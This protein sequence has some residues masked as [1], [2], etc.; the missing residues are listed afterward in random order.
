MGGYA[1]EDRDER[2]RLLGPWA[3]VLGIMLVRLGWRSQTYYARADKRPGGPEECA[4]DK[5]SGRHDYRH[6]DKPYGHDD[7]GGRVVLEPCDFSDKVTKARKC[8]EYGPL[9][10]RYC[11]DV[12]DVDA[13]LAKARVGAS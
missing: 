5:W 2:V 3:D 7:V 6:M 13:Q 9:R 8:N 11:G 1:V 4:G 10:C 12:Y